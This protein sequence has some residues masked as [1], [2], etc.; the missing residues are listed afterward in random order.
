MYHDANNE[1]SW[2][3]F[4]NRG[5]DDWLFNDNDLDASLKHIE[6]NVTRLVDGMQKDQFLA[7]PEDRLIESVVSQFEIEPL[8][9]HEDR[10]NSEFQEMLV[11]VPGDYGRGQRHMHGTDTTITIPFTGASWLCKCK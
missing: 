9:L 3:G 7:T 11:D 2:G 4:M 8:V 6:Y 10:K 1:M 5:G